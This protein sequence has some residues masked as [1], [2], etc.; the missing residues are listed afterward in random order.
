MPNRAPVVEE[1]QSFMPEERF[2]PVLMDIPLSRITGRTLE[3]GA[4]FVENIRA[5]GLLN[6]VTVRQ[7]VNRP[8]NGRVEYELSAGRRRVA[9]MRQIRGADGIISANVFPARTPM[10]LVHAMSI[11]ENTQRRPNPLTDLRAIE[12]LVQAGAN[13]E[14]IA[15]EL[16]L[17]IGT[18]RSRMRLAALIPALREAME[19][20]RM[21]PT[22][23]ERAARLNT[24]QQESLAGMLRLDGAA[25]ITM[26][27]VSAML[28]VRATE[29]VEALP[30]AAFTP[31]AVVEHA[32]QNATAVDVGTQPEL[33]PGWPGVLQSLQQAE[34]LMPAATNPDTE[35]AA[36][37]LSDL[38]AL[39]NEIIRAG[40]T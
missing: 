6:P 30:E 4:G 40:T 10:A 39:V 36:A 15:R 25:R 28:R 38:T 2:T 1:Q 35:S 5:I 14:Q 17:P 29:Q 27:D 8:A 13:E 24:E 9:A 23:G 26:D 37:W 22:T 12:A 32:L 19:A 34:R 21:S 31:Q 18:I 7:T 20:D 11:S 16:H 3:P 33:L